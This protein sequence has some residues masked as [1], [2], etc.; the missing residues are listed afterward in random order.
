MLLVS[1]VFE[2]LIKESTVLLPDT[3]EAY[4]L[5]SVRNRCLNIIAHKGMRTRVE[6]MLVMDEESITSDNDDE[7]VESRTVN[8]RNRQ[9]NRLW[10]GKLILSH[11]VGKGNLSWGTELSSTYSKGEYANEEGY[12]SPSQTEVKEKNLAGFA[13]YD[14]TLG[15]WGLN[16]G[17]RYEYVKSDYYSFGEWQ[18]GPS[19]RYGN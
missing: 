1:D 6:K 8:A 18:D 3:E 17:V 4:L 15:H 19:R 16:G 5:R 7:Q 14:L 9:N 10:A 12:V 11:P 2:H 13:E